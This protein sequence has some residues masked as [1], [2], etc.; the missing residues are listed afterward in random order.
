MLEHFKGPSIEYNQNSGSRQEILNA[1]R[2]MDPAPDIVIKPA[3]NHPAVIGWSLEQDPILLGQVHAPPGSA[4][5]QEKFTEVMTFWKEVGEMLWEELEYVPD[6]VYVHGSSAVLS[7]AAVLPPR[8][9]E[10]LVRTVD[11]F[12]RKKMS[13][14]NKDGN[15]ASLAWDLKSDHLRASREIQVT[16]VRYEDLTL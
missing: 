9:A 14:I 10:S 2:S 8:S 12:L 13:Q 4:L 5:S 1:L 16:E 7:V 11:N 6:P 15:T 3:L